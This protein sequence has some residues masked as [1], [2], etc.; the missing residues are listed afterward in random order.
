M[1]HD[2]FDRFRAKYKYVTWP[3]QAQA[4]NLQII[5][6]KERLYESL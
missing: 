1:K 2:L 3:L 4:N 5:F 6:E